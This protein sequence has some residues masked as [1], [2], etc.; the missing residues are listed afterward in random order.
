[1]PEPIVE[2]EALN[3]EARI[4]RDVWRIRWTG[5]VRRT[6]ANERLAEVLRDCQGGRNLINVGL[7]HDIAAAADF[8]RYNFVPVFEA[9]H[10][11]IVK[12]AT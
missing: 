10:W 1:M 3:D 9:A 6:G 11:R 7:Q 12:P 8:D 5:F 2:D 4:A